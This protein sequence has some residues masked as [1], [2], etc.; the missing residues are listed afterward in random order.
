MFIAGMQKLTLLDFPGVVACT[1][2]TAGCNF[3]CPWCHN[4]GLVL[5]EE[6]SDRLLESG[7]VL[8]FLEKRKGV[9]DG[10]CVT[11][12]EPLLHAELPDFLKRVK[13]LGY[14]VKLDTNGSFPERLEALVREKLA[15]RV[16]MDIKN[17]PSRYAETVG[18]RNLDLSAVTASKD[19]LLSDAVDYEFRTTVVRGLHTAESLLEAADWIRGAR[20]WFLQQFKD[21]GNLIHGEGLSAFSEDEMRR[22]LETVQKT[23]PAAQ[24]RGV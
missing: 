11:G 1:L 20:Q 18:L 8:S 19:F 22:L 6:A 14:R 5:P 7:E 13:D 24:L 23:N 16:A 9:L 15:D 12:G 21:S 10:V 4:A 17:G 3:R 2:F